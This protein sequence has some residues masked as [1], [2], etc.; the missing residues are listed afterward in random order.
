MV[1]QRVNGLQLSASVMY[2][3]SSVNRLDEKVPQVGQL[4]FDLAQP[5]VHFARIDNTVVVFEPGV[6]EQFVTLS[7]I[8][9]PSYPQAFFMNIGSQGQ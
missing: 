8:S 2:N 3:T 4:T 6:R 9:P 1:I 7:V 5:G